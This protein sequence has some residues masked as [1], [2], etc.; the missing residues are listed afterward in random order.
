M[1]AKGVRVSRKLSPPAKV[2]RRPL[3]SRALATSQALQDSF[4]RLVAEKGF[5]RTTVRE[6][7]AVAGVGVGT[8][9][10]YFG[11]MQALAAMCIH[12]QVRNLHACGRQALAECDLGAEHDALVR[13]DALQSALIDEVLRDAPMWAQLFLVERKVSAAE[14]FRRHY[15][16]YVQLWV[17]A[18]ESGPAPLPV[19]V[20]PL[21]RLL[22]TLTYGWVSQ[23]LLALGPQRAAG[24]L[25]QPL[26]W[27]MHALL[28]EAMAG[29]QAGA[30]G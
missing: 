30:S 17:S 22:H 7:A 25:R 13:A 24:Q 8:F 5:E 16:A 28:R 15:Q 12:N 29:T 9:Y 4:V 18:L 11:N 23:S 20:E 6:V 2:R 14:P 10:E 21:A 27:A 26:R 1:T 19:P 3:Q